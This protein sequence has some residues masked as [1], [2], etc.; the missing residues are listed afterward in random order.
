MASRGVLPSTGPV[1]ATEQPLVHVS[2]SDLEAFQSDQAMRAMEAMTD[3]KQA[4]YPSQLPAV[5]LVCD[6]YQAIKQALASDD[7]AYVCCSSIATPDGITACVF[8][9]SS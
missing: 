8:R 2:Y 4:C 7:L 3:H 5:T 6:D 1:D 9:H